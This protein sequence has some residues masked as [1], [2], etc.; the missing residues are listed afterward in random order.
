MQVISG[1]RT[2]ARR[3]TPMLLVIKSSSVDGCYACRTS[4]AHN[5]IARVTHHCTFF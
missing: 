1:E 4:N 5:A 3:E 2:L